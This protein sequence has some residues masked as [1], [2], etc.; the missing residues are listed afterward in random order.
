MLF[1]NGNSK[2]L[3]NLYKFKHNLVVTLCL[4][5]LIGPDMPKSELFKMMQLI[6]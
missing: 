2:L 6:K 4:D 1:I 5:I 3:E